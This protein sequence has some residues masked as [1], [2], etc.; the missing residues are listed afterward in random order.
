MIE[1]DRNLCNVVGYQL[2]KEGFQ[3]DFCYDGEESLWWIRQQVHDLI[4]L[5]RMLPSLSGTQVLKQMRKEEIKTPVI[6]ITALGTLDQKVEGLDLGADDYLV[7]PFAMKELLARIRAIVRRPATWSNNQI[8][9]IADIEFDGAKKTLKG[10]QGSCSL[11]KR[12]AALLEI[13]LKNQNQILPRNLLFSKV[14]GISAG[15]EEGNL[16]TYI[17]F[18]RNRLK[19]VGSKLEIKVVRSV[20][21]CLQK[22][23]CMNE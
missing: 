3:I 15:V 13:L 14:W 17:Y 22:E 12:E 18:L 11:S 23:N 1:D 5:D 9:N 16:D 8:L 21:Y 6:F 10:E 2:Q 20:G 19:T 4:L 7:K